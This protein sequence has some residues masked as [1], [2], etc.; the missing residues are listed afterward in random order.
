M[1]ALSTNP[2]LTQL[3]AQQ[4]QQQNVVGSQRSSQQQSRNGQYNNQSKLS[5]SSLSC[6]VCPSCVLL[7]VQSQCMHVFC[8][9]SHNA[10]RCHASYRSQKPRVVPS[11][12]VRLFSSSTVRVCVCV[13]FP[14]R[15]SRPRVLTFV[16][17]PLLLL[18]HSLARHPALCA[19]G[20]QRHITD[21][22]DTTADYPPTT[23]NNNKP[24]VSQQ[25]PK[26]NAKRTAKKVEPDSVDSSLNASEEPLGNSLLQSSQ[27]ASSDER[28][29]NSLNDSSSSA[30]PAE[31]DKRRRR[32]QRDHRLPRSTKDTRQQPPQQRRAKRTTDEP[33]KPDGTR[34]PASADK[35]SRPRVNSA[36]R[37]RKLSQS[38]EPSSKSKTTT[39]ARPAPSTR[40]NTRRP[41]GTTHSH[42]ST[43][44]MCACESVPSQRQQ[45]QL[46]LVS[47]C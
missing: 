2:T 34:K 27:S 1:C 25:A 5:S 38:G 24:R 10:S 37:Q 18:L 9:L 20:R 15:C 41:P 22:L 42:T 8:L 19:A 46:L 26:R 40:R 31:D 33:A 28:A 39:A 6:A 7:L 29:D 47:S 3:T 16:S 12:S 45:Q 13:C 23:S 4:Q 44:N 32:D 21:D 14:P 30:P 36:Y 17:L 11:R 43:T 35:P